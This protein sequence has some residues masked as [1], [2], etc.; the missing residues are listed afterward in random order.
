MREPFEGNTLE[1]LQVAYRTER[2][3]H[4]EIDIHMTKDY[5]FV[6]GHDDTFDEMILP[7]PGG[8]PHDGK[9]ISQLTMKEIKKM[10]LK[11]N[12]SRGPYR[13]EEAMRWG[14]SFFR[15]HVK[16]I[17]DVK[18]H[19]GQDVRVIAVRLRD[20]LFAC[21]PFYDTIACIISS[22]LEFVK[23]M[24]CLLDNRT[25]LIHIKCMALICYE[26]R[27]SFL[28]H[29]FSSNKLHSID[30]YYLQWEDSMSTTAVQVKL[31]ELGNSR[32]YGC[33]GIWGFPDEMV[34][35]YLLGQLERCGVRYMNIY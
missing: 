16:F 18:V 2:M 15:Q 20:L 34:P 21:S 19:E 12:P 33:L 3:T 31:K 17:L 26:G 28:M 29:T 8:R 10:Q 25:S 13:L 35:G 7:L 6:L 24:R 23:E 4:A 14:Y 9:E 11:V 32:I 27:D 5:E 22:D 1:A 30:G